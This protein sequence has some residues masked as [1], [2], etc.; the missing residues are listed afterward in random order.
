[1]P[2]FRFAARPFDEQV[3]FF[4]A[5]VNV[6]TARYDDLWREDH[7][8][9]FMVAGATRAALLSD[10]RD[11]VQR[12]IAGGE[13]LAQ[14]RAR[15]DDIVKARGWS[16]WKG[17]ESDAG[18]AWRTRLIYDTN[19]RQSYNAGRYAQLT[20]PDMLAARPYWQYRHNDVGVSLTPRPLH[21][22]WH[23]QVRHHS[24]PWWRTHFPQNGWHCKC[25]VRALSASDVKRLGLRVL[26]PSEGGTAGIDP[27]FDYSPGDAARSQAAAQAFGE[28]LAELPASWRDTA[29]RDAQRQAGELFADAAPQIVRALSG[30]TSAARTVSVGMLQPAAAAAIEATSTLISVRADVLQQLLSDNVPEAFVR[31][32]AVRL[33]KPDAIYRD[34]TTGILVY[35]WRVDGQLVQ[36]R[37][38]GVGRGTVAIVDGSVADADALQGDRFERISS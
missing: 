7:A 28:R 10:L 6:P 29:L 17:E 32:L 21:E 20:H 16:G 35:A 14:F 4:A 25:G 2:D 11:A 23:G 34:T 37:I 31:E 30:A 24:D 18:R 38:G 1:M 3:R 36:L 22:A 8:H 33:T 26:E 27:G 9:G 13:T 5:K 19:V 15:F 12:A